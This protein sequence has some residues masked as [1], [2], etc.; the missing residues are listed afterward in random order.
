M[1]T[2]S[3]KSFP[4]QQYFTGGVTTCRWFC[5]TPLGEN[6]GRLGPTFLW[7]SSHVPFPFADL[8]LYLLA[9]INH[10]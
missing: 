5:V 9:V 3:L 2:G 4:G 7:T 8:A 10:G 1:S 6:S